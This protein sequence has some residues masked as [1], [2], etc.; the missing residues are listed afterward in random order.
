MA[1]NIDDAGVAP[2]QADMPPLPPGL[3]ERGVVLL[4]DWIWEIQASDGRDISREVNSRFSNNVKNVYDIC[5]K[6]WQYF[7]TN[8]YPDGQLDFWDDTIGGVTSVALYQ[9]ALICATVLGHGPVST[10]RA[11]VE[12]PADLNH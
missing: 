8:D 7:E 6:G 11:C 2:H 5:W 1:G 9:A 10:D 12:H 4:Q 3:L